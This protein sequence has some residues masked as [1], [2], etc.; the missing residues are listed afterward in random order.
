MFLKVLSVGFNFVLIDGNQ[1][2]LLVLCLFTTYLFSLSFL[3]KWSSPFF[4]HVLPVCRDDLGDQLTIVLLV[5][6]G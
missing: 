2:L 4:L 3:D 5:F 6:L 1:L